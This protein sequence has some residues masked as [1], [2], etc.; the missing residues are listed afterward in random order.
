MVKDKTFLDLF[1]YSNPSTCTLCT[2]HTHRDNKKGSKQKCYLMPFV[3]SRKWANTK[4]KT[5][6]LEK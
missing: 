2:V 5:N 1:T 3:M 4:K 6:K